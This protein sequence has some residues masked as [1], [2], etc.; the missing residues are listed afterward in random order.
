ME[1]VA[2]LVQIPLRNQLNEPTVDKRL[3]EDAHK[4]C[5]AACV[6]AVLS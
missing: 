1:V 4:N 3:D 5:V 6:A 2:V